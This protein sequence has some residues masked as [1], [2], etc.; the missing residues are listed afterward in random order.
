M[1]KKTEEKGEWEGEKGKMKKKLKASP[2]KQA[3]NQ[4]GKARWGPSTAGRQASARY[5]QRSPSFL[6]IAFYLP[7]VPNCPAGERWSSIL[8]P[9]D[10][11]DKSHEF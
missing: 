4:R 6:V 2:G 7:G 9:K 8:L 11:I 1:K 3:E 5:P 10:A